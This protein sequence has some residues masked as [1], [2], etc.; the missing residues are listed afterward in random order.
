MLFRS[1]VTSYRS[2]P[3]T[4]GHIEMLVSEGSGIFRVRTPEL[5]LYPPPSGAGDLTAALFLARYLE[6]PDAVRALEL[7]TD[8]V[9]SILERTYREGKRELALIGAQE[10]IASPEPRFSAVR[11]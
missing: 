2:Q 8:S 6:T 11:L 3:R 1:L 5:P 7:T 9:Y 10:S 4:D